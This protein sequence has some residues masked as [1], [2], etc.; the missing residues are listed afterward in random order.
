MK[1]NIKSDF[2]WKNVVVFLEDLSDAYLRI[3]LKIP[4]RVVEV[5]KQ[6]PDFQYIVFYILNDLQNISEKSGTKILFINLKITKTII[7]MRFV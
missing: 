6:M 5:K 2:L 3:F 1:E 4:K 7:F